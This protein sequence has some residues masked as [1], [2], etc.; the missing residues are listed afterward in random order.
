MAAL[1]SYNREK[2]E[3]RTSSNKHRGILWVSKELIQ[4]GLETQ[5]VRRLWIHGY[6]VKIYLTDQNIGSY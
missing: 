4:L 3:K 6:P 5:A 1:D 2:I